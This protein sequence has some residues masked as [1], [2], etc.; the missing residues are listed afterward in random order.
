MHS[1]TTFSLKKSTAKFTQQ[2]KTLAKTAKAKSLQKTIA[3]T[4]KPTPSRS[5]MVV[6]TLAQQR[7]ARL[8]Q[9]AT[10]KLSPAQ[11]HPQVL[12][13]MVSSTSP[14]LQ[15][16]LQ[17]ML[18]PTTCHQTAPAQNSTTLQTVLQLKVAQQASSATSV[19]IV[20]EQTSLCCH[21]KE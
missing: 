10:G 1:L 15:R 3:K 6:L 16:T 19:T 9:Q 7:L 18:Q 2:K 11:M 4:T 13:K 12:A 14:T 17:A 8:Q 21:N 5:T 20:L